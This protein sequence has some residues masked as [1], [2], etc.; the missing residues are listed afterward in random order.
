MMEDFDVF[1]AIGI[2]MNSY[3]FVMIFNYFL[4]N[5]IEL[6]LVKNKNTFLSN[7]YEWM[8]AKVW[9]WIEENKKLEC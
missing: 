9:M 6:I 5:E 1:C 4:I 8:N 3:S 7:L 2:Y